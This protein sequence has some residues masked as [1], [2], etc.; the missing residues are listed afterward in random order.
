MNNLRSFKDLVKAALSCLNIFIRRNLKLLVWE[1]VSAPKSASSSDSPIC[2]NSVSTPCTSSWSVSLESVAS[3]VCQLRP[4]RLDILHWESSCED[5]R[6]LSAWE[7]C[8]LWLAVGRVNC[9]VLTT[10]FS[11]V[12]FTCKPLTINHTLPITLSLLLLL[13]FLDS[14][15]VCFQLIID[16]RDSL[17]LAVSLSIARDS[18]L[19][20]VLSKNMSRLFLQ[21]Q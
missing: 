17:S 21:T 15:H 3:S 8:P 11:S 18:V 5:V 4:G 14:S 19:P 13:F 12:L 20:P 7:W 6:R 1:W 10:A 16:S 9:V 2:S